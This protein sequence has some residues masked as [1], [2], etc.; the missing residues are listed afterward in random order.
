MS[1]YHFL[2]V[3]RQVVGM[4]PHQFTLRMRLQRAALRLARSSD[5]VATIA[6]DCGVGDIS[7][8]NRRFRRVMGASPLGFRARHAKHLPLRETAPR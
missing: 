1:P 2:R 3:F 7:T 5:P 4:S 8:F 6:L